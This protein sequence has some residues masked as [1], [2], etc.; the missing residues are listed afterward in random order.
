MLVI[1][2]FIFKKMLNHLFK[3]MG[4]MKA[5]RISMLWPRKAFS[6]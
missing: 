5:N 2:E 1:T 3:L 4:M 6:I